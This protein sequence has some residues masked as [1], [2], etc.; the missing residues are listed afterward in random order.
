MWLLTPKRYHCIE[1]FGKDYYEVINTSNDMGESTPFIEF[2]LSTIKASLIE[3]IKT[4]DGM[5][6]RLTN[7][8][9][10]RWKKIKI[11]FRKERIYYE[12]RRS[13]FVR[14][15]SCYGKSDSCRVGQKGKA[16][17]DTKIRTLGL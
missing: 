13:I 6:D 10:L 11:F 4:S 3:A 8:D 16:S 15:F 12:L 17:E 5:I 9:S 7:K 2:M 14:R 1:S